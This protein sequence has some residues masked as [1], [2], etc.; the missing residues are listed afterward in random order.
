MFQSRAARKAQRKL[1]DVNKRLQRA[2]DELAVLDEQRAVFADT[3][4][5]TRIRAL[6]SES[7]LD[8]LDHREAARHADAMNRSRAAL[9]ATIAELERAQ[10]DCLDR[11]VTKSR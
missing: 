7:P 5:E 3:E 10:D 1:V 11:L 6:V 4:D 8:N 9:V 2:R